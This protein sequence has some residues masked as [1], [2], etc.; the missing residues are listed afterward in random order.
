[1]TH[2][3]D[4]LNFAFCDTFLFLPNFDVICNLSL[5]RRVAAWNLFVNEKKKKKADESPSFHVKRWKVIVKKIATF[6]FVSDVVRHGG[7]SLVVL[8]WIKITQG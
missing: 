8:S 4:T 2:I 1:M 5:N 7:L 6:L 3:G